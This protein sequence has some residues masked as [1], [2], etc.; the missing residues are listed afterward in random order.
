ME[1]WHEIIEKA[2]ELYA[3]NYH[4]CEAVL[5][6]ISEYYGYQ[7]DLILKIS[8]PFG[9]GMIQNGATCG[10]LIGAYLCMGIFKGR[11][12]ENENRSSACVPANHIF[13]KF[14]EKFGTSECRD[15]IG[16]DMKDPQ[17][18]EAYRKK[19]KCEVCIPLTKDV[20]GWILEELDQ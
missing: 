8:T 16:Y 4:C 5:L 3:G 11:T 7:D 17:V 1:K 9:G 15:I 2:G 19:I 20:T 10:S 14:R 13:S 12:S 18:D 6:A